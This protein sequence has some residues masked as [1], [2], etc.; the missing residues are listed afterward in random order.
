MYSFSFFFRV[1]NIFS[2][3]EISTGTT[4]YKN[5]IGKLYASLKKVVYPVILTDENTLSKSI[6]HDPRTDSDNLIFKKA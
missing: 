1:N 6:T 2:I 4:S 5:K 3:N